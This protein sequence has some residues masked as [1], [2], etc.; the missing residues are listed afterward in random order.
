MG[1][2]KGNFIKDS[3]LSFIGLLK[4]YKNDHELFSVFHIFLS[5]IISIVFIFIIKSY[6][7]NMIT[8]DVS[9]IIISSSTSILAILIAAFGLFAAITDISFSKKIYNI[10]QLRNLL[11]PFWFSSILWVISLLYGIFVNVILNIDKINVLLIDILLFTLF[12]LFI[13]NIGYTLGLIGDIL[14]LTIRRVQI[15]IYEEKVKKLSLKQFTNKPKKEVKRYNHF[16]D[17]YLAL[18]IG[19]IIYS[20]FWHAF[21]INYSWV[22]FITGILYLSYFYSG[23]KF[24]LKLKDLG[25][26]NLINKFRNLV[27]YM[28][29]IIGYWIVICIL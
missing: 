15:E 20:F 28:I 5:L 7:L 3:D 21:W 22:Y 6:S 9:K 17:F 19:I 11:F 29:I 12:F 23:Y 1:D 27:K 13:I 26:K 8:K 25:Q 24:Y 2:S 16:F 14:K 18:S 4:H 10:G